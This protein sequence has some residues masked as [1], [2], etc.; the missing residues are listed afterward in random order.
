MTVYATLGN[1]LLVPIA[2]LQNLASTINVHGDTR[3]VADSTGK[4]RGTEVLCIVT[5]TTY[6][7]AISKGPKSSDEWFRV[8]G[9]ALYTPV[10][11]LDLLGGAAWTDSAG[12]SYDAGLLTA[13][14]TDDPTST[15]DVVL[16]AGTY[17]G[18]IT[19]AGEGTTGDHDRPLVVITGDEDGPL[20][21][22]NSVPVLHPTAAESATN[23]T[24]VDFEFTLTEENTVT[25][26]L[27]VVNEAGSLEAGSAYVAF[28]LLEAVAPAA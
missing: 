8:D 25:I 13:D 16:Q 21:T 4:K 24:V 2:D 15:Q 3:K 5:G 11:I 19:V 18:T 17:R 12:C 7:E 14:G 23:K 22:Y 28:S 9:G 6:A 1:L 20:F 10:N 27:S 26:E